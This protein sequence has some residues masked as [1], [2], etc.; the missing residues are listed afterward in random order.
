[1]EVDEVLMISDRTHY[2][3]MYLSCV[4]EKRKPNDS[5]KRRGG[6]YMDKQIVLEL[7][8]RYDSLYLY[9]EAVI[10]EQIQ[11]LR[12]YFPQVAL[13]YSMK[14]NPNAAVVDCILQQGIGVDAASLEEVRLGAKRGLTREEI[15]YS[16]PGKTKEEIVQAMSMATLIADSISEVERIQEIAAQCQEKVRIG[17]RLNPD[18]TMHGEDGQPSK[19]GIDEARFWQE[20][21][22]WKKDARIQIVGVHI[23]LESQKL[24]AEI[25]AS[26]Y[27]KVMD[28]AEQFRQ[29]QGYSL[30]FLNMGSGIGIPYTSQDQPLDLKWL[31]QELTN[32][33][34]IFA[35]QNPTTKVFIESG[36]FLV[37][38]AGW[39]VTKVLDRKI[40]YGKTILILKNTLN[41]FL[42]P[43][44]ACLIA[45]YTKGMQLGGS[46]PL[47]T[48]KDAF[49]CITW[50]QAPLERVTLMGNLCTSA[51]I[52]AEDIMLPRLECGDVIVIPNAGSYGAVLSPMQFSLQQKPKEFFLT[53]EG[54]ILDVSGERNDK[55]LEGYN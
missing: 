5:E 36:R 22:N 37:G 21:P 7:A 29:I 47:F 2:L 18:F 44:L 24:H 55:Q 23:H 31:G 12:R 39:Y 34:H 9:E 40:S 54:E 53:L 52:I 20:M 45:K 33:L 50:K 51:D 42:R 43:S 25:L 46:E 38:K 32:M 10:L 6:K 48:A 4:A 19:F 17:I 49:P 28:V 8:E 3:G 13:L 1:M 35:Q 16:A 11:L 27:R 26:Y 41:G 14:A 15:Y 30:Q